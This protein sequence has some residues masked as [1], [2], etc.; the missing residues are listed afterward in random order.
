FEE[1]GEASSF[2]AAVLDLSIK[3][4]PRLAQEQEPSGHATA[5]A[6]VRRR[7]V[8]VAHYLYEGLAI[9]GGGAGGAA[10]DVPSGHAS[11][12]GVDAG[13]LERLGAA[14]KRAVAGLVVAFPTGMADHVRASVHAE[15]LYVS[16]AVDADFQQLDDQITHAVHRT[17]SEHDETS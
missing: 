6:S 10:N 1:A 14:L 5:N 13:D 8:R 16:S 3:S 9:A 17:V 12:T 2:D 11:N 4:K 15:D 7:S